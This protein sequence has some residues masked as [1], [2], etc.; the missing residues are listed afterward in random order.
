[1]SFES[2]LKKGGDAVPME[3]VKQINEQLQKIKK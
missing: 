1:M 2:L 3:M